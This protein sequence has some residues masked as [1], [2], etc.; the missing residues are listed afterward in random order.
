MKTRSQMLQELSY[1]AMRRTRGC[2]WAVLLTLIVTCGVAHGKPLVQSVVRVGF[3]V[4]DL[5]SSVRF[6][7]DV[8]MFEEVLRR[9]EETQV[10]PAAPES[11]REKVRIAELRLGDELLELTQFVGTQGRPFPT[12]SRSNDVWFQHIAII[13]SDMDKAYERLDRHKVKHASVSPQRLPDWNKNAGGIKAFYFRDPD[14][15]YLEVLEFPPD[16]GLPKWHVQSDRLFLGIDHKGIVVTNTKKSLAYY[17]DLLGMRI[18]GASDNYGP[19]QSALNNVPDA[20]LRITTLRADA[21]P[22][23]ELLEYLHP[24][25][26]RA[27]P[28]DARPHDLLHWQTT[29]KVQ[30]LTDATSALSRRKE[31]RKVVRSAGK[32]FVRDPDG[33]ALILSQN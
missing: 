13:V 28:A 26:G 8:L 9:D 4:R 33:H 1:A 16:K 17:H 30:S 12:D 11:G 6:F 20:H 7:R 32:M 10:S 19:E 15:H 2:A 27:Y 29:L 14:G 21:G 18:A 23:I 5:D 24:L 25:D 22:G 3:T 31:F